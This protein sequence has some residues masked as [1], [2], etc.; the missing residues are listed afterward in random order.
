MKKILGILLVTVFVLLKLTTSF[1]AESK[2]TAMCTPFGTGGYVITNALE[3]ISKKSGGGFVVK[4]TETPG[5]IFNIKKLNKSPED[6]KNSIFISSKT[7]A[8]MSTQAMGPYKEKYP[9]PKLI[10]N[11][12]QV[13]Y[14]LA[15]TSADIKTG[16]DLVGKKIGL[17]RAAQDVY[18]RFPTWIVKKGWDFGDK[19]E[20]MALGLKPALRALLDGNV[21]AAIMNS[22][23]DLKT[24]KLLT[25]PLFME[26][27]ASGKTVSSI[28]WTKKAIENVNAQGYPLTQITLNP[29]VMKG[30]DGAFEG[31]VE[32]A[33]WWAYPELSDELAYQVTKLIIDNLDKFIEYH[34]VLGKVM[35][36]KALLYGV[37]QKDIHPGALKAYKEAGYL[38]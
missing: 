16:K 1:A 17:G 18:G 6:K 38:E 29:G 10:A 2:V 26:L 33:G 13:I 5:V 20:I 34:K 7:S 36:P 21:D 15:S 31:V 8:W 27:L 14:W 22:F 23:I 32:P 4:T 12:V 28:P 19:V 3:E 25:S 11:Y 37:T 30:Y 9:A 24:G 35:T